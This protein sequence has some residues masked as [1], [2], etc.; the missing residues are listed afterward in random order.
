MK[1]LKIHQG[2]ECKTHEALIRQMDLSC[3]KKY[4]M[5]DCPLGAMYVYVLV[6]VCVYFI[7]LILC[8]PIDSR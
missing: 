4:I 1:M 7:S 6:C 8:L 2:E 5:Y 3:L